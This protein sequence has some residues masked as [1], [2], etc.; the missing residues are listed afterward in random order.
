MVVRYK[1]SP[2]KEQ[3]KLEEGLIKIVAS[4]YL[5]ME[6]IFYQYMSGDAHNFLPLE[7]Q[8]KLEKGFIKYRDRVS[9]RNLNEKRVY[10]YRAI[11][12]LE[13]VKIHPFVRII[14]YHGKT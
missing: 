3:D 12:G 2:L 10:S 11:A 4:A 8:D 13:I 1:A 7:A 6:K 9:E 5:P 14:Y